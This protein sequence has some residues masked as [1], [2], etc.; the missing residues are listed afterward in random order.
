MILSQTLS[1]LNGISGIR[2]TSADPEMPL[3]SAI[4]PAQRPISSTTIT[5]SWALA[6]E[7][8][9]SIASVDVET[10]VSNPKVM[11]VLARS[12]SI[13]LGTPTTGIPIAAKRLAR[14]RE[15]SPPTAIRTSRP[16]RLKLERTRPETSRTST[17]PTAFLTGILNG[18]PLF[19]V[20]RIVPPRETMPTTFSGVS[21]VI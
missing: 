4:Q 20:P 7:C 11:T 12:L 6:V 9:L 21:R 18:S 13:V 5:R 10:A 8:S 2:I 1:I 19:V 3:L 15:P 17:S 16:R 14:R